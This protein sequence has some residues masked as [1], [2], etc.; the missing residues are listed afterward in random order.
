MATIAQQH[1]V[2]RA[3]ISHLL[4]QAA[5]PIREQRILDQAGLLEAARLYG[6]GWS[7]ARVGGRL[8]F[9]PE[10][11]RQHL[12]RHGVVMRDPHGRTR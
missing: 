9:D 6:S 10:T 4:K 2:K 1:G 11:I 5:I 3:A 8:G 7:L 12:R